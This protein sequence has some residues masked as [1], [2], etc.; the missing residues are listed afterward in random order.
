MAIYVTAPVISKFRNLLGLRTALTPFQEAADGVVADCDLLV[1]LPWLTVRS[2]V[3]E[4]MMP[5]YRRV[6]YY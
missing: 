3:G 2:G 5:P 1:F 6:G 4:K